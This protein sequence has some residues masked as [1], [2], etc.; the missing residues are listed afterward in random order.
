MRRGVKRVAGGEPV[1]YVLGQTEFMG[2][3]FKT[4]KRALIPRPET[5]ILVEAVLGCGALWAKEKPLIVDLGT[6]SGCIV[7][8]LALARPEALYAALDVS[9][10]A[11][12]L[13]KENAASLAVGDR[14]SFLRAEL[15]DVAEPQMADAIVSNPP[16]VAT[17][18]WE[19]LPAH[20]REHEPRQALDGGPQGLDVLENLIQDA[21]I[22]LK[23]G[24]HLFL[25][26]GYDQGRAVAGMLAECQFS[27][28]EVRK[29]LSGHDRIAVAGLALE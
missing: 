21:S 22:A 16:Y 1:Q 8:S 4:D 18:A 6:G 12:E 11:I 25:E 23:P 26:I 20:I 24:G 27:G 29:D 13:A 3:V 28:I 17:G 10:E 7:I 2:H 9:A 19:K 5:E 15:P 14:V